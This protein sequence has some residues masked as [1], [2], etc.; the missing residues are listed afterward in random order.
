M[1][2]HF[3]IPDPSTGDNHYSYYERILKTAG[4][5]DKQGLLVLVISDLLWQWAAST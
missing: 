2:S 5:R 3:H 4:T 1:P